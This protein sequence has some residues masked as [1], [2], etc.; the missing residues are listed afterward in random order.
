MVRLFDIFLQ[1]NR[2]L[3]NV[4]GCLC[5]KFL[6]AVTVCSYMSVLINTN[7]IIQQSTVIPLTVDSTNILLT[8]DTCRIDQVL[9]SIPKYQPI[10]RQHTLSI[11]ISSNT[12]SGVGLHVD[13]SVGRH[14]QLIDNRHILSQLWGAQ[15]AGV[16]CRMPL[17]WTLNVECWMTLRFCD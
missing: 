8:L 13:S 6:W 9:T 12:W 14:C 15:M 3:T 11:N 4:S 17:S 10:P 5:Y 1:K 16:F 2:F 7:H